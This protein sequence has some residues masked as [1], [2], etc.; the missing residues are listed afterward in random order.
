MFIFVP[1]IKIMPK[2]II[3]LLFCFFCISDQ[4]AQSFKK[5]ER[6]ADNDQYEKSIAQYNKIIQ[7]DSNSYRANYELGALLYQYMNNPSNAG[8]YLL[9]AEKLSVKDTSSEII[10]GL[11]QYYQAI[12][13]YAKAILYYNRTL[14]FVLDDEEGAKLKSIIS[15]NIEACN[16]SEN[17]PITDQGK[18]F[19][20]TN[21]GDSINT[22][23]PD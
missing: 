9:K 11:A 13:D 16:Y 21:L 5:A 22:I 3:F 15:K 20:I 18:K 4:F 19:K 12:G 8:K 6:A 17:H 14:G 23:Y 2:K 10:Y 1:Q 7:K